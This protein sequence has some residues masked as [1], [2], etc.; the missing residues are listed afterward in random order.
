MDCQA[1]HAGTHRPP[2]PITAGRVF[3]VAMRTGGRPSAPSG[4][5]SGHSWPL[6][7]GNAWPGAP[8]LRRDWRLSGQQRKQGMGQGGV[9]VRVQ[10]HMSQRTSG[11]N[12]PTCREPEPTAATCPSSRQGSRPSAQ[13]PSALRHRQPVLLWPWLQHHRAPSPEPTSMSGRMSSH[14]WPRVPP[15]TRRADP[16]ALCRPASAAPA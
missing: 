5:G 14:R 10:H 12:V 6:M 4:A 15:Q 16:N 3:A 2:A 9:G 11:P 8:C 1:R 13:G 7:F